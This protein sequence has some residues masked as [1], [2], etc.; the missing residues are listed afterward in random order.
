MIGTLHE[1]LEQ[2]WRRLAETATAIIPPLLAGIVILLVAWVVAVLLRLLLVRLARTAWLD[3]F[4]LESGVCSAMGRSRPLQAAPLVAAT[5][6]WLVLLIGLLTALNAFNTALTN[7][8][9]EG[10]VFLLPKLA[11]AA[12]ILVAG[13]WLAQ[14][15]A[16][17]VLVW[18]ANEGVPQP[19]KLSSGV[20]VLV[21]FLA[22]VAAAD[23]LNFARTVF[24]GAFLLLVGGLVLAG[25]IALGLSAHYALRRRLTAPSGTG[26]GEERSLWDHL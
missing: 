11:V 7:R 19:R 24:L 1:I 17:S 6:Y 18:A 25:S 15:L 26:E 13:V 12:L 16:R 10:A 21:V 14:F 5:I 20:R 9:V 23:H 2:S 4:L 22:V 8:I 3:R